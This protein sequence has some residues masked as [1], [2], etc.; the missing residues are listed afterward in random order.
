MT[1]ADADAD[2][3]TDAGNAVATSEDGE[4]TYNSAPISTAHF[5]YELSSGAYPPS[6]HYV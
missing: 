1:G 4:A 6:P 5:R 2:A 3:D